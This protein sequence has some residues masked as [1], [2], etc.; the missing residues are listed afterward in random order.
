MW[1]KK[2][3]EKKNGINARG[4]WRQTIKVERNKTTYCVRKSKWKNIRGG[5]KVE[6]C[7]PRMNVSIA[8]EDLTC[9]P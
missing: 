9:Y 7:R 8:A 1:K 4:Q 3:K 5:C 6:L 2:K